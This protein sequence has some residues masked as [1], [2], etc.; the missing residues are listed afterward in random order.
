LHD[1]EN[2]STRRAEKSE[3]VPDLRK[4]AGPELD[5]HTPCFPGEA[6]VALPLDLVV[7]AL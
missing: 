1:P 4:R 6:D 2:G 5:T 7:T 3:S